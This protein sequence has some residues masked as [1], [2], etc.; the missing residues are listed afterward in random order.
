[1]NTKKNILSTEEEVE[2][3]NIIAESRELIFD[4]ASDDMLFSIVGN[5]I[6]CMNFIKYWIQKRKGID[7]EKNIG[8]NP[9]KEH[10]SNI[11]K[12]SLVE[13]ITNEGRIYQEVD[14]EYYFDLKNGQGILA[15]HNLK[16]I[17]NELDRL[18]KC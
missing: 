8:F 6:D 17:A 16:D 1:M 3:L 11:T 5:P 18:N 15:S 7:V 4:E 10:D 12:S 2:I 14:G 9:F 13:K